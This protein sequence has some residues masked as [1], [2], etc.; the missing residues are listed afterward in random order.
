MHEDISEEWWACKGISSVPLTLVA[1]K[2]HQ[3]LHIAILLRLVE[4]VLQPFDISTPSLNFLL[5]DQLCTPINIQ[6][7]VHTV[8]AFNSCT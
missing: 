1:T 6:T 4:P 5:P 7:R 8:P 3:L 2:Y